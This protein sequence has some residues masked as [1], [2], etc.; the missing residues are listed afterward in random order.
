[1]LSLMN[2]TALPLRFYQIF[3]PRGG[4]APTEAMPLSASRLNHQQITTSNRKF[5]D[6]LFIVS[7]IS[8]FLTH[9]VCYQKMALAGLFVK[10]PM[11]Q[12]GT[13]SN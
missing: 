12:S 4:G 8:A 13:L 6:S 10:G 5:D 7:M 1:M 9:S 3:C 2:R 11:I